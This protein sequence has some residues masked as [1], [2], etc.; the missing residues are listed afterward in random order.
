MKYLV[1]G[2]FRLGVGGYGEVEAGQI[3]DLPEQTAAQ[4]TYQDRLRPV[5]DSTVDPDGERRFP[6]GSTGL[7]VNMDPKPVSRRIAKKE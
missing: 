1:T 5:L 4:Y 2:G 3:I 7:V 6:S